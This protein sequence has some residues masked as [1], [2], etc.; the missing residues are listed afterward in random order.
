[1]ILSLSPC[2]PAAGSSL[3]DCRRSCRNSFPPVPTALRSIAG[4][5]RRF[6]RRST[7]R[8]ERRFG[9]P[10]SARR[11]PVPAKCV[12][13]SKARRAEALWH[14]RVLPDREDALTASAG[15]APC[16][17]SG[18]RGTDQESALGAGCPGTICSFNGPPAFYRR[19]TEKGSGLSR[20]VSKDTYDTAFSF[21]Y[22]LYDALD[23]V[24]VFR[25][26]ARI[27]NYHMATFRVKEEEEKY[28]SFYLYSCGAEDG[29]SARTCTK[30]SFGTEAAFHA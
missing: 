28:S 30:D 16:G 17:E 20:R 18:D 13:T 29:C 27:W 3:R 25:L 9:P 4:V 10:G 15:H 24:D 23:D 8:S 6:S 1:M 7:G 14:G 11:S 12:F 2:E 5:A 22:R 26:F 19:F 21:L